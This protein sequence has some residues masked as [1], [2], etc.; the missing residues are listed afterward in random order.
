[1]FPRMR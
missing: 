1:M